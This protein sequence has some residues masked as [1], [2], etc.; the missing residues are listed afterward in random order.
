MV[1][2]DLQTLLSG[3]DEKLTQ[4]R[5]GVIRLEGQMKELVDDHAKHERA[6]EAL[7]ADVAALQRDKASGDAVASYRKEARMLRI[8]T[9]G[10]VCTVIGTLIGIATFILTH[11]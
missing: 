11:H 5:D 10:C 9:I 7:E 3:L 1:E 6:I 4:A 2:F 8:W